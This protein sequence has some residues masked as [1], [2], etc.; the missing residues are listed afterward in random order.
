MDG[1]SSDGSIQA[2]L[3]IDGHAW[4]VQFDQMGSLLAT[5]AV[6]GESSSV[7]IWE[8]NPEGQWYVLSKVHGSTD[9]SESEMNE[10]TMLQ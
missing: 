9:D 5:S 3:P 4:K 2:S 6:E 7:C 8:L 1:L 10:G